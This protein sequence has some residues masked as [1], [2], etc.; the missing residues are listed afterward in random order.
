MSHSLS[1]HPWYRPGQTG[2]R[3]CQFFSA[4]IDDT[5]TDVPEAATPSPGAEYSEPRIRASAI[6]HSCKGYHR[7]SN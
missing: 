5:H 3:G 2:T 7:S 1:H 6:R 4:A